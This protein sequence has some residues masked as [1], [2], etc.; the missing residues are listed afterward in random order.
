MSKKKQIHYN[1]LDAETIEQ[2]TNCVIDR[3]REEEEKLRDTRHDRRR[4]NIKLL[5]R[6][7]RDISKHVDD[8]AYEATQLDY[9]TTLQ[10]ILE[11]MSSRKRDSFRVEA[12][13]ESVATAKIITGH[14]Q[15]MLES[16]ELSCQHFG[17]PEDRRR[18]RVIKAMYID[19]KKL[20]IDEIADMENIDK[21]T[22]YRDIESATD[23]LAVLFFGVYGLR[24]L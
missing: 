9:D 8:A 22:A 19:Q 21:S 13:R 5:L 1:R 7:Y 2:I 6:N 14:M 15:K 11:L 24:F 4:A 18:Y 16:Y 20:T 12:I 10:D 17:K 3:L 23:K